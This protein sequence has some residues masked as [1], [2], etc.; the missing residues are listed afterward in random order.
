MKRTIDLDQVRVVQACNYKGNP[1]VYLEIMDQR[2][3]YSDPRALRAFSGVPADDTPFQEQVDT[4]LLADIFRR[5]LGRIFAR[6]LLEDDPFLAEAWSTETDR[7]I[8]YVKPR[9]DESPDD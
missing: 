5:R 9:L 2:V 4:D 7:K 3:L 1:R 6:L 8:D